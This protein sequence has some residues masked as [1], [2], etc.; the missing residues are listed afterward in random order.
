[1]L[2]NQAI[3]EFRQIY[4]KNFHENLPE[5]MAREKAVKFLELFKVVFKPLPIPEKNYEKK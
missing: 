1:M 4:K 2:S 3:M 5:N